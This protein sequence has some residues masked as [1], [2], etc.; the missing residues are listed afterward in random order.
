MTK[1]YLEV[2]VRKQ[3]MKEINNLFISN[4]EEPYEHGWNS[5]LENLK[6]ELINKIK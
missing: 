3:V 6:D 5:A 4:N 2:Y 1:I